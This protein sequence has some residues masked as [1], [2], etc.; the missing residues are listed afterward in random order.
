MF[1]AALAA[2]SLFREVFCS[3]K[4]AKYILV[5]NVLNLLVRQNII[6]LCLGDGCQPAIPKKIFFGRDVACRPRLANIYIIVARPVEASGFRD[7]NKLP[8]G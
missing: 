8:R 7:L 4:H 6:G 3:N 5:K 2:A 1:F